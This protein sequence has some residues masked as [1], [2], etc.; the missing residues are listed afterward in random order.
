MQSLIVTDNTIKL[1][2]LYDIRTHNASVQLINMASGAVRNE[3]R[4]GTQVDRG[5]ACGSSHT[6]PAGVDDTNRLVSQPFAGVRF[7]VVNGADTALAFYHR[8]YQPGIGW[9][10]AHTPVHIGI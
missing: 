2:Q 8:P 7:V 9:A 3:T 5:Y 6:P 1:G 4:G 10:R